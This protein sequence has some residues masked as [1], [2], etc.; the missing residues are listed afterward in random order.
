VDEE[1]DTQS[2][3]DKDESADVA[4]TMMREETVREEKKKAR[5]DKKENTEKKKVSDKTR[6]LP[7]L[8]QHK[9]NCRVPPTVSMR[10]GPTRRDSRGEI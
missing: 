4:E 10:A 7:I 6:E 9:R 1:N 8:L 5:V 2:T 3:S